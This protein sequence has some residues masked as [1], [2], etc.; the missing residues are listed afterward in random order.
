MNIWVHR[1]LV[2][3]GFG[4]GAWLLTAAPAHADTSDTTAPTIALR[5]D[6]GGSAAVSTAPLTARSRIAARVVLP[7]R[8]AGVGTAG[9][10]VRAAAA[11]RAVA[12]G[13]MAVPRGLRAAGTL[14]ASTVISVGTA[15]GRGLPI[16]GTSAVVVRARAAIARPARVAVPSPVSGPVAGPASIHGRICL[17][18]GSGTCRPEPGS[19]GAPAAP[20][21]SAVVAA[22]TVSGV[23]AA[24]TVSGVVAAPTVSGMLAALVVTSDGPCSGGGAGP[25]A[26]VEIGAGLALG[27]AGSGGA[28]GSG[29]VAPVELPRGGWGSG[30]SPAG[31]TIPLGLPG[32][33]GLATVTVA[34]PQG[35]PVTGVA[36]LS[37]VAAG[38]AVLGLGALLLVGGRRRR[39]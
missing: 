27:G 28:A 32:G 6:A 22:P 34:G 25:G 12:A 38:L 7:P 29:C 9:H 13:R 31:V 11:L 21:V 23:V 20:T 18:V 19:A 30:V 39:A 3:A 15:T 37:S 36:L 1:A 14:G 24:P 35:L 2:T 33:T 10:T 4:L 5:L 16:S 26:G 17:V 8:S